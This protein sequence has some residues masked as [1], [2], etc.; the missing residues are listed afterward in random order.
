MKLNLFCL[1]LIS[2]F[3]CELVA[4]PPNYLKYEMITL[5]SK[6]KTVKPGLARELEVFINGEIVKVLSKEYNG[7]KILSE[8]E[9][10]FDLKKRWRIQVYENNT[11]QADA[12]SESGDVSQEL[13]A[14]GEIKSIRGFTC[15]KYKISKVKSGGYYADMYKGK[16]TFWITKDIRLPKKVNA[17]IVGNLTKLF[18][19]EFE[20]ALIQIDFEFTDPNLEVPMDIGIAKKGYFEPEK[21]Q[22]GMPW[23][24]EGVK[25]KAVIESP[26]HRDFQGNVY[27]SEKEKE[28]F[29]Q[30]KQLLSEITGQQNP[31]FSIR[32]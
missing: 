28:I 21:Q 17:I 7:E 1:L 10:L 15:E 18:S 12:W 4:Q 30:Q 25:Y 29:K 3:C 26:Y 13:T 16:Y 9:I 20:G 32:H 23:K 24:R 11:Y 31:K 22:F 2:L 27:T 8:I 6:I 5:D 14:T 19:P